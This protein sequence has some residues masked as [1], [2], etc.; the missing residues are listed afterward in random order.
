MHRNST[1][2]ARRSLRITLIVVLVLVVAVFLLA[3]KLRY[4]MANEAFPSSSTDPIMPSGSLEQVAELPQPPGNIV[5]SADGRIFFNY[6]PEARPDLKVFEWVNGRPEPFPNAEFQHRR[7]SGDPH[8]QTPFGLRIDDQ[9]RLWI[10]DSGLFGFQQPR[11]L[12]FDIQTRALVH[13][14]DMP[15]SIAGPGSYVQDFHVSRDGR[16]IYLADVSP[17]PLSPAIIVYDS[18]TGQARRVLEKHASV[19]PTPFVVNAKGKKMAMLG[20]LLHMNPGIDPIALD[21]EGE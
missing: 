5:V 1:A 20:G 11:L 19:S 15:R 12:A 2:P 4:G 6:H 10:L 21:H 9:G 8:F 16:H 17:L 14:W 3:F 18:Q 13:Q 7:G